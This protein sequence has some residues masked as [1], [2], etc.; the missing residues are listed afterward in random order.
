MSSLFFI[1]LG[2]NYAKLVGWS[3]CTITIVILVQLNLANKGKEWYLMLFVQQK[4]VRFR[5]DT[6]KPP[7]MQIPSEQVHVCL[8]VMREH[9]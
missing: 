2:A 5:N 1:I 7:Y 6:M 8:S 9:L 4:L 3:Q